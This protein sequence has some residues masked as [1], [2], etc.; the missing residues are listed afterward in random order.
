[1]SDFNPNG[2]NEKLATVI[3]RLDELKLSSKEARDEARANFMAVHRRVDK[4]DSEIQA[5]KTEDAIRARQA[6]WAV[7]LA[8]VF[9][10][11]FALWFGNQYK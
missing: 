5:L 7:A 4:Q 6:K 1:M 3:E 9:G 8:G 2:L 10:W 11:A